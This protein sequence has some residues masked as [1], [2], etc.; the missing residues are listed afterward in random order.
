MS[1]RYLGTPQ[2]EHGTPERLG[3]L[4]VNLGTPDS[5]EPADVRRFL[6]EFLWDPRVIEAPR[7]IW[8]LALHGV[9]LR[10]RPAKSSHAYK[11]IWTQSGSPLLTHSRALAEATQEELR[12][13]LGDSVRVAL[14]MTYGNPSIASVMRGLHAENVRRLLVLPLYP[15]Y[16][17][18]TTGS[19]FD[20][21]TS[22]LHRW[23]WLPELRFITGYHDEP[24]YISAIAASI[25]KHW[26]SH[27]RGHLLF[28]FHGIPQRYLLAGDPYHCQCVK[29]ARLVSEQLG[30]PA[31]D[32]SLSF[33]SQVGRE[34]WLRP[35]TDEVL[36]QYAKQGRASVTV[37]C[38]GFATDCLET[39]EEIALRNRATF[40]AN[41]GRAFS[42]VPSLNAGDAHV[43][44]LCDLV[45][46]QIQGWPR[47]SMSPADA[48]LVKARAAKYGAV[49]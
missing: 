48:S 19:V 8:W 1:S 34:E 31:E 18:T 5:P 45:M 10:I 24:A 17:A 49:R 4:L 41:G 23:R 47:P 26:E 3:I 22:P 11:Q 25:R 15:Q 46:R 38:P 7:W 32:W 33:Q 21:V 37:A 36:I 28:S 14:A 27:E 29:T 40:L 16:S 20:R 6:A 13:R 44:L 2:Y 35:Y 9:I 39:L 30:L 12:A 43:G 42:Y